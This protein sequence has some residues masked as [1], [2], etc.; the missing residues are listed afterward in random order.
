MIGRMVRLTSAEEAAKSPV[1]GN[2][3]PAA[4]H[5][6][7]FNTLQRPMNL[8]TDFTLFL[9]KIDHPE[10]LSG[11]RIHPWLGIGGS[12]REQARGFPLDRGGPM[13]TFMPCH[14]SRHSS[15]L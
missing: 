13:D 9:H 14:P 6:D 11:M 8:R 1:A 15:S 2:K 7:R 4:V 10:P 3:N 12:P 5:K